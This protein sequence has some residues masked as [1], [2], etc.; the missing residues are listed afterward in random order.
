MVFVD[1]FGSHETF[2]KYYLELFHDVASYLQPIT[3]MHSYT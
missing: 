2:L 3:C 1:R